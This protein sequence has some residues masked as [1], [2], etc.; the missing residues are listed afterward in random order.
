M[1][2]VSA[3]DRFVWQDDRLL[4]DDLVFRLDAH[5][6][7]PSSDSFDLY[8]SRPLLEQFARLLAGTDLRPGNVMELGIW[9]GGSTALWFEVLQPQKLVALDF[10][11]RGDSEYFRWYLGSRG[12]QER[13]KTYWATDQGD[14]DRLREIVETEFSGSLDLVI[15][16]ASHLYGPT[17][18]S[19]ETLFPLLRRGGL[20]IIED[21]QWEHGEAFQDPD[22]PWANQESLTKLVFHLVEATGTQNL[23]TIAALTIFGGFVAIERGW[24]SLDGPDEFALEDRIR[25]RP[26]MDRLG[27]GR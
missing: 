21:W 5:S 7:Q 8:K 12:L 17:K 23:G 19:F 27:S 4:L 13:L 26:A 18:A 2:D 10:D 9:D 20:Y 24:G 6:R 14:V 25:R 16:D 1:A 15:D 3:F 11:S 22:H